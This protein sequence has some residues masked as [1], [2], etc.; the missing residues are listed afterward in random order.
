MTMSI[1]NTFEKKGNKSA[2]GWPRCFWYLPDEHFYYSNLKTSSTS[3]KALQ[4]Y[5]YK[6]IHLQV[7]HFRKHFASLK[8]HAAICFCRESLDRCAARIPAQAWQRRA[9]RCRQP[10]A[11]DGQVHACHRFPT[12]RSVP[13]LLQPL[14][15][16]CPGGTQVS[17]YRQWGA[18]PPT[19]CKHHLP[20]S[21]AARSF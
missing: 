16:T 5:A 2:L 7:A 12:A 1:K 21:R 10:R 14:H 15:V 17:P 20:P 4:P 11:D 18:T 13:S 19:P 8:L 3:T 6:C 9:G